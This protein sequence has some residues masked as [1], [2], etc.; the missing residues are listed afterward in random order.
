VTFEEMEAG[1]RARLKA[2]PPTARA[3]P[4]HVLRLP[5]LDRADVNGTFW[6]HPETRR[7]G[8][9]L[10]DLEEDR[11]LR[12]ALGWEA[13]GSRASGPFL[14]RTVSFEHPCLRLLIHVPQDATKWP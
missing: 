9:F 11:A 5:D 12:A 6:G 14:G 1:L 8:E 10:I 13:T 3:E 4:L 2:L 7:L